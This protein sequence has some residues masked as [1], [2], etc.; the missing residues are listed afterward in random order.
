[1]DVGIDCFPLVN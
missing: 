1:M